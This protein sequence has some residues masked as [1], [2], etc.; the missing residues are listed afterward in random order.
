M[1]AIVAVEGDPGAVEGPVW[2]LQP[3]LMRTILHDRG[4]YGRFKVTKYISGFGRTRKNPTQ[5][6]GSFSTAAWIISLD[7]IRRI[8]HP[9]ECRMASQRFQVLPSTSTA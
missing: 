1:V 4:M 6:I 9:V 5:N 2:C 7:S 3:R 8:F